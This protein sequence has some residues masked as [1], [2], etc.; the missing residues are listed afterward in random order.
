MSR[1][2]RDELPR[3]VRKTLL[4]NEPVFICLRRHGLWA[5]GP[6][7]EII[8]AII[9]ASWLATFFFA[10]DP[11]PQLVWIAC[12]IPVAHG[13]YGLM[14]WSRFRFIVTGDRFILVNGF[15][16]RRTR[17]QLALQFGKDL[18]IQQNPLGQIL[19]FGDLI[20]DT[21]PRDHPLRQV[22]GLPG[23]ADVHLTITRILNGEFQG[24]GR[25]PGPDVEVLPSYGGDTVVVV[26]AE[27]RSPA[28]QV[29]RQAGAV[30]SAEPGKPGQRIFMSSLFPRIAERGAAMPEVLRRPIKFP[31]RWARRARGLV[32]RGFGVKH[33]LPAKVP[34]PT[35]RHSRR[36]DFPD[37]L[38]HY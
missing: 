19:Q 29:H 25:Q 27:S 22:T 4:R 37:V 32:R 38:D 21:A 18:T 6:L 35:E 28:Q 16:P 15:W 17:A 31:S 30:G 33:D 12:L 10:Y 11:L 13:A 3:V 14:E 2:P 20:L 34:A 5:I 1:I 23:V 9:A 36:S 24:Y 8:G 26:D 7:L